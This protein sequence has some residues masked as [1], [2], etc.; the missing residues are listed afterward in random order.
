MTHEELR[1]L[2][3]SSGIDV[4]RQ[5]FAVS[6]DLCVM[7][8]TDPNSR[9]THELILLALEHRKQFRSS[10]AILSSLVREVG[11]FP[12]LAH[13]DL[14]SLPL[15]DVFAYEYHRPDGLDNVVFHRAQAEI[16]HELVSGSSVILSAPTSFGK[17]LI[18]DAAIAS[19]KHN[20][21]AVVLPTIALIDE[22]RR[23]LTARFRSTYKLL[24]HPSQTRG[25]RNIY[26]ITQERAPL[27]DELEKVTLYVIDEFYKLSPGGD[28]NE[29]RVTSL[30]HVFYKA[31]KAKR[32]FYLLGP[33]IAQIPPGFPERFSCK[34]VRTDYA[35]V[36]TERHRV[37]PEP[38][39]ETALIDLCRKLAAANERTLIY[40]SSP[41]RVR[42]VSRWLMNAQILPKQE[43]LSDAA[44]WIR[45]EYHNEWLLPDALEY[46]IGM[47]HGRVPRALAQYVVRQFN[48]ATLGF[49]V[50]TSTLIE[51]V[52]TKA[53][54][55]IILDDRLANAKLDYFTFNNISGRSGRMSEHFIG[56]VWMFFDP[57]RDDL[58]KVDFPVITQDDSAPEALL[59]Q[60]SPGDLN[61]VAAARIRPFL[62]QVFLDPDVIRANIGV[63]PTGQIDIAKVIRADIA[64]WHQF[65]AW[66]G[67][68]SYHELAACCSLL[69][70]HLWGRGGIGKNRLV[71]SDQQLAFRLMRFSEVSLKKFLGD[72]VLEARSRLRN[73]LEADEAIEEA[74]A[75]IR[76]WAGHIVP[77]GLSAL[78][79]IQNSIFTDLDM[80]VGDYSTYIAAME[81]QFV[82][83][84]LAALEEYG[85]PLQLGI[86]IRSLLLKGK[87][88][89]EVLESARLIG[90][91]ELRGLRT[92]L[93][94]FE[95]EILENALGFL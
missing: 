78:D 71:S 94:P 60:I 10:L 88:L 24:T 49:L 30:N 6:R 56:H 90:A 77:R 21:I 19:D 8:N 53:K 2:L 67:Y 11:L 85:I 74:L 92:L 76:N 44:A 41:G 84:A 51:G 65:L 50:C 64:T 12:Y 83:S 87:T 31:I 3:S 32:Q 72:V 4:T 70:E 17:S 27:F 81:A 80:R 93:G 55:V 37:Y 20:D 16:Y 5:A 22:T 35:T 29:E 57:P 46:G 34:F 54:N 14:A 82:D 33:N 95:L 25:Q 69:W 1:A 59:L 13:F 39:E 73:P 79:R 9:A 7:F 15:P 42:T 58:P 47:H 91:Q 68:P 62:G 36:V 86:K 45:Q 63:D 23:R 48:A 66:R 40:C 75:F 52:N 26:V 28:N 89:D 38:D 61:P 18:I 43:M